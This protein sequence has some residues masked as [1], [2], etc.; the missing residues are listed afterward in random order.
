MALCTFHDSTRSNSQHHLSN[1]FQAGR[2]HEPGGCRHSLK[3]SVGP[4]RR[5][6]ALTLA[7]S[8][9][10]W[11]PVIIRKRAPTSAVANSEQNINAASA[12]GCML[13]PCMRWRFTANDKGVA[14]AIELRALLGRRRG[15]K[16][17]LLTPR[18]NVGWDLARYVALRRFSRYDS[19]CY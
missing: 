14:D 6:T 18:R 13:R 11:E 19:A 3:W 15:G 17:R 2:H 5:S 8:A 9:Q 16:A 1:S 12:V 7:C 10:D 4:G